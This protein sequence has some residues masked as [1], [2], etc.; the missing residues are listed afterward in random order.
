[1]LARLVSNFWPHVICPPRP[2][3]LMGLQ[4]WSTA[5]GLGLIF[6]FCFVLF[7]LRQGLT[8]L[9]RHWRDLCLLQSP[10]PGFKR[11]SHF[12]L[13]SSWDYRCIP[14]TWTIFV[15]FF[16][17]TGFHHVAKAGLKHLLSRDLIHLSRPPKVLGLHAWATAPS[18][19][20]FFNMFV[21]LIYVL[22]WKVTVHIFLPLLD[23]VVCF[24]LVNLF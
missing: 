11:T 12:S 10:P 5:T 7:Y 23:R 1:M 22:F 8:L 2:L 19:W 21:G 20:A 4:A 16:V 13:L 18:R 9:P 6:M 24:F 17:E 14:Y 15:I 3:R